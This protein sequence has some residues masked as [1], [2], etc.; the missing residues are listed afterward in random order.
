MLVYFSKKKKQSLLYYIKQ[1]C[2]IY[3]AIFT[4]LLIEQDIDR[5][6]TRLQQRYY[7]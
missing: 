2:Q 1:C 7:S 4:R 5:I 3:E 6:A